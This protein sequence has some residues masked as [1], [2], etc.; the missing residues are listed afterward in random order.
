MDREFLLFT[1]IQMLKNNYRMLLFLFL[2]L[3]ALLLG[4]RKLSNSL[5]FQLFGTIYP[6]VQTTQKVIA[7]TFDDGPSARVDSILSLLDRHDAKATFFLTGKGI[8][9]KLSASKRIVAAGHE[10]GNHSYSHDRLVFKSYHSIKEEIEKTD[11]LI[12]QAGFA[13]EAILFRPPYGKK[14]LVLPYY[15]SQHN[16]KTITWDLTPEAI[17]EVA[18][19]PKR[20]A[21]YV[22]EQAQNGSIVLMHIMFDYKKGSFGA[23]E[24]MLIGLKEKGFAFKTVSELLAYDGK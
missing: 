3:L 24:P 5:S 4:V 17:P 18:D 21:D 14:L 23:L 6:K 2:A 22:V 15:L 8:K 7:L 13:Q 11:A 1:K 19:D 16:R 9:E 10:I 20:S 12:R